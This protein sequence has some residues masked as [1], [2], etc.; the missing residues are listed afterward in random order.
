MGGVSGSRGVDMT[1][2]PP[3]RR[4]VA[5][6]FQHPALY[7]HLSVFDNLAFGLKVR[8]YRAARRGPRSTRWPEC[9]DLTVS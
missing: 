9:W 3:H 2:V 8:G 5:M 4:D 6:V 7:P 1:D